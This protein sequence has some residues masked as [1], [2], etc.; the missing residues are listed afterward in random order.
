MKKTLI[1]L[2]TILLLINV[3]VSGQRAR[4]RPLT[5][6]T[7]TL[8][9]YVCKDIDDL[10]RDKPDIK[11]RL[12]ILLGNNYRLFMRNI[13]VRGGFNDV[14]GFLTI[15]GTEPNMG[16]VEEAVLFI[17]LSTG[18]IHCA[19]LSNRFGGKHKVFSEDPN[20]VPTRLIN[21]IFYERSVQSQFRC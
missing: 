17:S 1:G 8:E 19:I 11:R 2:L 21:G 9:K 13:V 10:L 3:N 5:T 16:T 18:K 4:K 12:R 14:E 6:S 7:A 20:N 15:A